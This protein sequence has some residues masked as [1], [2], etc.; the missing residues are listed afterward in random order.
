M[1]NLLD[2]HGRFAVHGWGEQPRP[3]KDLRGTHEREA[4][5]HGNEEQR[6][7]NMR[8]EHL[9]VAFRMVKPFENQRLK[10]MEVE[11]TAGD[12]RRLDGRQSRSGQCG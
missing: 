6:K 5:G 12:L 8:Q 10:L 7:E 9:P 4:H 11:F 1:C 2:E 3:L